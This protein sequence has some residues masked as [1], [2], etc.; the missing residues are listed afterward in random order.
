MA[1]VDAYENIIGISSDDI[2]SNFRDVFKGDTTEKL[3]EVHKDLEDILIFIHEND[4]PTWVSESIVS[5]A[6]WFLRV[7]KKGNGITD[8]SAIKLY[9]GLYY[10]VSLSEGQIQYPTIPML[11][12]WMNSQIATKIDLDEKFVK[13][14]RDE[15]E[16][17]MSISEDSYNQ[18]L[19]DV[20]KMKDEAATT[21]ASLQKASGEVAVEKYAEIFESQAKTHSSE[22]ISKAESSLHRWRIL[23]GKAQR[24]LVLGM[25]SCL[26]LVFTMFKIDSF[27]KN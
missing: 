15:A 25:L 4:C 24:W 27:V 20:L 17:N 11:T 6:E 16:R 7:Y 12:T 14:A 13:I 1:L 2:K 9:Q 23:N 18:A 26:L 5:H 21:I 22:F 3:V 10:T 19:T 8:N